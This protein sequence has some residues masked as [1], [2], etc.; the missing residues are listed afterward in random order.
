M[1]AKAARRRMKRSQRAPSGMLGPGKGD[2]RAWPVSVARRSRQRP[3][4]PARS[5]F[6]ASARRHDAPA[7]MRSSSSSVTTH[8]ARCG[9]FRRRAQYRP[10]PID[11][12]RHRAFQPEY[13]ADPASKD[14]SLAVGEI[15]TS[16][17][18]TSIAS[19]DLNS[20]RRADCVRQAEECASRTNY[21]RVRR[22]KAGT[23]SVVAGGT[24]IDTPSPM[25]RSLHRGQC[26]C[27]AMYRLSLFAGS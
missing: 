6:S 23:S 27:S 3:R 8:A 12:R 21:R 2:R 9:R 11:D 19:I 10:P 7:V 22:V 5:P 15:A 18:I 16:L 4:L 17:D 13:T 25:G 14:N 20:T 24:I 1:R 26:W